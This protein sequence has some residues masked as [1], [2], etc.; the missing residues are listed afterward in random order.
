MKP[1]LT[2]H[3]NAV[4]NSY[5]I[6][7]FSQHKIFGIL[8]LI[9]SFFNITAGITG[10]LCTL[11]TIILVNQ[12]GFNKETTQTGLYSFNSLLLGIGFGTFFTFNYTFWLWLLVACILC[13]IICINLTAQLGKYSLPALSIPFII[14]FWIVLLATNGYAGMGLVQKNSAIIFELYIGST[15]HLN[16]LHEYINQ[17]NLPIYIALFFRSLS[18][19]LF[20]NNIIAGIII[21]LGLLIHSRIAFSLLVLGFVVA[22][23]TNNLIG[24]YPDGVSNYHLGAN[25]MMISLAIGGFFLIP[26][27]RSYLLA[28]VA[29]LLTFL[30]V[31]G[32]TKAF[33][34]FSLPIF[35]MPFSLLT[36]G[37]LYFFMLRLNAGKL[38]ITAIQNY[39][40]ETNLYQFLN[41]QERLKDFKYFPISLPFMGT[42]TVSQDYNGNITHKGDWSEALDFVITD[43]DE[44]TYEFPG[45]KVEHYYCFNKPVLAS[46]DGSVEEV[47]QHVDDNPIGQINIQQNWGNTIIIKHING[48]YSKVSHL[49]KNTAKVKQGDFVK[50]GDIIALCGNSGRSP[51][52]HLHFQLQTTPYIGSKTLAYPF[53]YFQ[54]NHHELQSF[55]IPKTGDKIQIPEIN[56]Y[57]KQ[58]FNFQPGYQ[59]QVISSTGITE[60]WEVF[61]DAYNQTYIANKENQSVA[62]FT[63][64]ANVFY[65]TRFYG[66][67]T[68]LL[69]LFYLSAYK[70]N[71]SAHEVIDVYATDSESFK[72]NLWLQ[73]LIAPFY[74]FTKNTYQ[75]KINHTINGLVIETIAQKEIFSK[76]SKIIYAQINITESGLNT[77]QIQLKNSKNKIKCTI[78]SI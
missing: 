32:L 38:Q 8:L 12:L 62:Y 48:L 36:I 23:L 7:F 77:F 54:T 16:Q 20:Q 13:I 43:I 21:A 68:A 17:L 58:A 35:S 26:S 59:V 11:F 37:L 66:D 63:K 71:F 57:L 61:A 74:I 64:N 18:A 1:Q 4:V 56:P 44:K 45:N 30:L 65:F 55:A 2:Y 6:L 15:S 22:C 60:T 31:N 49:K 28:V 9:A 72:P 41:G 47:I 51:E 40:P 50:Q 69:Y 29:V 53:S 42:W 70:V 76:K 67:K 46:A 10:F 24:V 19:V 5:A 73:D 75:N 34:F 25:F 39:S 52:P 3:F 78:K 27:I 14:V 33:D